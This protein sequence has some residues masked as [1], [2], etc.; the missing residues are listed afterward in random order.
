MGDNSNFLCSQKLLGEDDSVSR[1]VVMVKQPGLFSPNLGTMS[2]QFFAQSPQNFAAE[3]GIHSL[4]SWD[5]FFTHN[6]LDVKESDEHALEIT[7][8]PS[9]HFGPW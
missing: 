8:H 5:K 3:L 7:F 6:P 2:S 1:G 9:G 4:T